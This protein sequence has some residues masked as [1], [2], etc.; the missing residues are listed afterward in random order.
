MLLSKIF[1][2]INIIIN[3]IRHDPILFFFRYVDY[4]ENTFSGSFFLD[5]V[6]IPFQVI[7][8]LFVCT[9]YFWI[10]GYFIMFGVSTLLGVNCF[11]GL[12]LE[13]KFDDLYAAINN[14]PW[15]R[16]PI[17]QQKIILFMIA[18]AQK[19][20]LLTCGSMAPLNMT[21]YV[22]VSQKKDKTF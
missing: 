5:A 17:K 22:S 2:T 4:I 9:F 6:C 8:T 11:Y 13:L 21:T 15:Y 18:R 7:I 10:P 12:Y 3:R 19:Q 14:I 1:I 20:K 16:L